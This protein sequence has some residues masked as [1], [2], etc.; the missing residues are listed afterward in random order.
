[1]STGAPI[2]PAAAG[3]RLAMNAPRVRLLF[4]LLTAGGLLGFVCFPWLQRKLGLFDFGRWFLDSLAV[5]AASDAARAGIDTQRSNP[6]DVLN[7]PHSYSDWWYVLGDLGLTRAD[8]FLVGGLWVLTFVVVAWITL[9]PRSLREAGWFAMLFLSPPVLLAVIRANNDLVVFTLLGSGALALCGRHPAAWI[10]ALG[11]IALATGLKFYPVVAGASFLLLRPGR[12]ALIAAIGAV[13]VL[14]ATL[15]DVWASLGRGMFERPQA[16]YTF[17]AAVL[18]RDLG[19]QGRNTTLAAVVLLVGAASWLVRSGRVA[20]LA[21]PEPPSRERTLFAVGGVVLLACF[22][23]GASYSYRCIFALWLAPWLWVQAN[24]ALLPP[25]R[26]RTARCALW[27]LAGVMWADG[28]FCLVLN[29]AVGPMA[30]EPREWSQLAWRVLTQ[31]LSWALM[32]LV[33]GWW[34]EAVQA[35]LRG[36]RERPAI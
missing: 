11:G 8:N 7:R 5:L 32:A 15:R 6:L 24:D 9:A 19:W 20:G 33:A 10:P 13:L 31:P 12:T 22:V 35:T 2:A 1:M 3:G 34:L 16:L 26:R 36:W 17:G 4:C 28:L 23:A 25:L 21:A 29:L 18:L 27:L 30:E 14:G